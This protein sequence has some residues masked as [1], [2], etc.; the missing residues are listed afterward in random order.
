MHN[1][2][3]TLF[4]GRYDH[5]RALSDDDK[6]KVVAGREAAKAARKRKVSALGST[7]DETAVV[8]EPSNV[9]EPDAESPPPAKK[10]AKVTK[11]PGAPLKPTKET[12]YIIPK[13][14]KAARVLAADDEETEE[15]EYEEEAPSQLTKTGKD[16]AGRKFG[17][18][19]NQPKAKTAEAKA[20]PVEAT[21]KAKLA[22][23]VAKAKKAAQK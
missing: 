20:T 4:I 3:G 12:Q 17:K 19:A 2:D 11:A 8:E 9:V 7:V 1:K 21:K 14:G 6:A 23:F 13:K 16:N 18:F 22:K 15:E 5:F 10:K